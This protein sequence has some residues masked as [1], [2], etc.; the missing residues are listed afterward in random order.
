V[1]AAL[2]SPPLLAVAHGSRDPRHAAALRGLLGAVRRAA[3][4]L[5]A[6]L[7]FL[8]LC[9]PSVPAAL[10]RLVASGVEGEYE[11]EHTGEVIVVPLFLRHGYH[12]THDIPAV[13][14]QA[15]SALSHGALR[16][17][18]ALTI[19]DPL[20][21]DPLLDAAF[22]YR[23]REQGAG[24]D[25]VYGDVVY[26]SATTPL[27]T[28]AQD[29][30]ALRARGAARITVASYFLAPGLLPDRARA[31]ARAA[32]VPITAPL[33]TPD[34]EPPGEL[35]QLVLARYAAAQ[36]ASTRLRSTSTSNPP[37]GYC[38]SILSSASTSSRVMA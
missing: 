9:G 34:D 4:G 28:T 32:R 18:P 36:L 38:G 29:I 20:G 2:V 30:A 3:P 24:T 27:S 15:R 10:A 5:R 6:E 33:T 23:L 31:F 7:G 21:P 19:A 11:Y 26:A 25:D 16:H 22:D 8:D 37:A 13:T 12:V 17:P 14:A 35:V 1:T